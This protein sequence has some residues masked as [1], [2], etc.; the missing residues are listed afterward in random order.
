MR[1]DQEWILWGKT[2]PLFAVSTWKGRDKD[3]ATPWGKRDFYAVGESDWSDFYLRWSNY[4]LEKSHVLEIGCGAGRI[5][6]QL[7]QCFSFVTAT[8]VS[9][10][11]ITL[12]KEAVAP[13]GVI[14]L[15]TDGRHLQ[16][17]D[18]SVS[19]VF[20]CHVFQHF[21]TF[22]DALSVFREIFRVLSPGGTIL[23][24]L[25]LFSL[26][27]S[28]LN[29]LIRLALH[30]QKFLGQAKANFQR[31]LNCRIMRGLFFETEF[32]RNALLKIGF[33]RVEVIQFPMK[34]N[35]SWHS[36]VFASKP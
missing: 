18:A 27:P 33:C 9:P 13:K 4:G 36:V 34:S 6:K 10:D 30:S 31:L 11:Q 12:A 14:F 23:I 19:A 28:P 8:D 35:S 26:P 2:D 25:P 7:A 22:A 21:D 20:S 29:P 1:S 16:L 5:T 15:I 32:L 3:S 17:E 24:H